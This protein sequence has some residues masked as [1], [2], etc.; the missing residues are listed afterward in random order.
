[1]KALEFSREEGSR[2][3]IC[4]NNCNLCCKLVFLEEN[5]NTLK[6]ILRGDCKRVLFFLKLNRYHVVVFL[7]LCLSVLLMNL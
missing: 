4:I 6:K 2:S 3:K 7:H 5:I 1:M